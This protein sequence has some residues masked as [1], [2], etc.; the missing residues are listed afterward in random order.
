MK[1]IKL[2][3]NNNE[4]FDEFCELKKDFIEKKEDCYELS[5]DYEAANWDDID[6]TLL[7]IS[8][9]LLVNYINNN[10]IDYKNEILTEVLNNPY[11]RT[12]MILEVDRFM[13]NN[14]IF[15]ESAFMKFNTKGLLDDF[16]FIIETCKR[17][18][19]A[20]QTYEDIS[21]ELKKAGFDIKLYKSIK[22]EYKNDEIHLISKKNSTYDITPS[23]ISEKIPLYIEFDNMEDQILID[24]SFCSLLIM[25][26]KIE[27][28]E[29]STKYI[30]L[31]DLLLDQIAINEINCNITLI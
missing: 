24:V 18:E 31:Y 30:D 1:V 27:E 10:F 26:L 3:I 4:L 11:Y 14:E 2:Y 16:N 7:N 23:N 22:I 19:K 9:Y 6:I 13:K 25:I 20:N 12:T 15:K 29:I 8:M 28:I 17:K 5:L 21:K